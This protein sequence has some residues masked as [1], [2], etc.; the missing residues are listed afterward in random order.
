VSDRRL[1]RFRRPDETT[2]GNVPPGAA[3]GS[4]V[5]HPP[6]SSLP[7]QASP[8]GGSVTETAALWRR[9]Q[10]RQRR[11]NV[12]VDP[13]AELAA[14]PEGS[15]F[16]TA[17]RSPF[18]N[19]VR[20]ARFH[21]LPLPEE[22]IGLH[23]GAG[24][25]VL[26]L[27]HP[28]FPW[29]LV[30]RSPTIGALILVIVAYVVSVREGWE[31]AAAVLPSVALLVLLVLGFQRLADRYSAYVI[32]NA[33]M[34][35]MSGVFNN[36]VESIPW[37]RVT[38]VHFERSFLERLLGCA[39]LNI[40]SANETMGLRRMSGIADP[41]EFN[42]HLVDMVV[43]KQGPSVPLGRRSDYNIM[44]PAR[45]LFRKRPSRE[46]GSQL[47]VDE[48]AP[49]AAAADEGE[50]PDATEETMPAAPTPY[51]GQVAPDPELPTDLSNMD[52]VG[53]SEMA[54]DR[55]RQDHLLGREGGDPP[56]RPAR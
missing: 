31:L 39:T 44:P 35:R 37:I 36:S 14:P 1:W 9:T 34:I 49:A 52:A 56:D 47:I 11:Q 41:F 46:T 54:A 45:S 19:R 21:F 30:K 50:P 43:A 23:L 3:S 32:T 16:A 24:E 28:S 15:G 27:D 6:A 12:W 10:R 48:P 53:R 18:G 13:S 33:R 55:R 2:I 4:A 38:D 51:S 5:R 8:F 29:F 22:T 26:H 42:R 17:T 25:K 40:E 7:D 20:S